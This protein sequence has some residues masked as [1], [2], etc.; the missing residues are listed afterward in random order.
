MAYGGIGMEVR[1]VYKAGNSLVFAIP[2]KMLDD[3]DLREGTNMAVYLDKKNRCL[4]AKPL[5]L[6]DREIDPSF[7]ARVE[8]FIDCYEEALKELAK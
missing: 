3:L 8:A 4:I 2:R 1:K 7:A 5:N 6:P